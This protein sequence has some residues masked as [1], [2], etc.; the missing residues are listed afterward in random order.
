[1]LNKEAMRILCTKQNIA[2]I[3]SNFIWSIIYKNTKLLCCTPEMN[4]ILL[5]NH[6][7]NE[8]KAEVLVKLA[9]LRLS[10]QL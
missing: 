4:I 7:K 8:T 3:Y 6:N 10:V 1:M 2:N 5:L 9:K